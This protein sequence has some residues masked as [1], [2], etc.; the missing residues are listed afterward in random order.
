MQPQFT[1]MGIRMGKRMYNTSGSWAGCKSALTLTP[2][3]PRMSPPALPCLS[4]WDKK[5][6]VQCKSQTRALQADER[7]QGKGSHSASG[8]KSQRS[9]P[10]KC[11]LPGAEFLLRIC[12]GNN[13]P[14]TVSDPDVALKLGAVAG[15]NQKIQRSGSRLTFCL[16]V[17]PFVLQGS[18]ARS[19]QD[20][21]HRTEAVASS[22]G[23]RYPL[24]YGGR[25]RW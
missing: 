22:W 20:Q 25:W 3:L 12:P 7:D 14:Q 18:R 10:C 23:H 13:R 11:R 19:R 1:L 24:G 17:S 8:G 15:R 21:G 16:K 4:P 6:R 5:R 9:V 2:A